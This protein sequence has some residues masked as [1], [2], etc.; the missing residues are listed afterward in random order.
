LIEV[1]GG[2]MNQIPY[3]Y[4]IRLQGNSSTTL[5]PTYVARVRG[6]GLPLAE[7]L[8][9]DFRSIPGIQATIPHVIEVSTRDENGAVTLHATLTITRLKVNQSFSSDLLNPTFSGA[10]SY[11]DSDARQFVQGP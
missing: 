3:N 10:E 9:N 4:R 11:W 2:T 6:D 7:V 5:Y 1:P 8:L